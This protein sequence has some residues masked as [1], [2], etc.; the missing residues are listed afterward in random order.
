MADLSITAANVRAGTNATIQRGPAGASIA[1]GDVLYLDTVAS[2]QSLKP[3]DCNSGA[4]GD[5]IR[6][7]KGIAV[8]S[9]AA[10]QPVDYVATDADFTPGGA[11]T[12]GIPYFLSATAGK[13]C[14]LAD[15]PTGGTATTFFIGIATSATKLRLAPAEGAVLA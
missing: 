5:P 12:A 4:A 1:A 15:V 7:V 8:N 6:K 10:G 14:P 13:M 2:P 9:A 11:L 3:A